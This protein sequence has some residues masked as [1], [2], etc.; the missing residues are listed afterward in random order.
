[1]LLVVG[2]G[3]PGPAYARNRHNIGYLAVDAIVHRHS[4][5]PFRARF[6]GQL[7]EGSID[8]VKTLCLK[9]TTYMNESGRSVAAAVRFHKLTLDRVIV[10]HDEVDL[11]PGKLRVKQGGGSAGHN[12]LRS[13]DDHLGSDYWRI[14]LGIGHPGD[15]DRVPDY[16]LHDFARAD[17]AWVAPLIDAVAEA[18][19]LMAHGEAAKFAT[20]VA[21]L[22]KP[23]TPK[24][25]KPA[26][27]AS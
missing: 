17:R 12:G 3:N 27:P 24:P 25:A 7:A 11:A 8:G 6:A 20:K 21:L 19:P 18:F 15:K 1:M 5:Q 9:P 16:V 2:L 10:I 26:P 22:L 14:R 23:P 13:I 4:F